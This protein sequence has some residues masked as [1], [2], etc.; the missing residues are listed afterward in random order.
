MD[1]YFTWSLLR[2]EASVLPPE[3]ELCLAA[4][5][6]CF[7]EEYRFMG[8]ILN[9][10]SVK[11]KGQIM[12]WWEQN[13]TQYFTSELFGRVG[14]VP[15]VCVH[16]TPVV[17]QPVG[18][19]E[20]ESVTVWMQRGKMNYPSVLRKAETLPSANRETMSSKVPDPSNSPI[21][22]PN[23]RTDRE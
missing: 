21:F 8:H 16:N 6:N 7:W 17:N 10:Q 15:C 3:A 4:F 18:G 1:Q 23:R 13:E 9:R 20:K 22:V 12:V 2:R 5:Q 11:Q 19:G 14:Q